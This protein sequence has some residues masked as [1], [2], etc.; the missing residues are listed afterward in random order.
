MFT[1]VLMVNEEIIRKLINEELDRRQ[2]RL[3]PQAQFCEEFSIS[4]EG[5]YKAIKRGSIKSQKIGGKVFVCLNQFN[6]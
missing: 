1:F 4:R 2:T 5:L 3:I 6:R